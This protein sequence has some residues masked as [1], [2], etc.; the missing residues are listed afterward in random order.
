MSSACKYIITRN[1]RF[2]C[3]HGATNNKNDGNEVAVKNLSTKSLILQV[4]A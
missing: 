4:D 1:T 3:R 2:C